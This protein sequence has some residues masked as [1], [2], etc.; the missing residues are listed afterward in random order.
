MGLCWGNPGAGLS[1]KHATWMR[2]GD[3]TGVASGP[4][5]PALGKRFPEGAPKRERMW[6]IVGRERNLDLEAETV[7][8]AGNW[9]KAFGVLFGSRKELL[10][11]LLVELVQSGRFQVGGQA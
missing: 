4:A 5:T 9:V 10:P 11:V 1:L 7:G 3:V 6:S 2:L 8:E